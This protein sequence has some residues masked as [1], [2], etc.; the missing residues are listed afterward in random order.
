V[1]DAFSV[2]N[3]L[4]D[5]RIATHEGTVVT[6]RL[7]VVDLRRGSTVAVIDLG[8]EVRPHSAHFGPDGLLYVS[9][10][11]ANA[12]YI[13]DTKT[14]SLVGEIPTGASHTHMFVISPDGRRICTANNEAGSVSVLDLPARTLITTIPISNKCG[15]SRFR[16]MAGSFLRRA[17][18]HLALW[19]SIL[20]SNA[21]VRSISLPR[22]PFSPQTELRQYL[23]GK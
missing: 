20:Q 8:K 10:E 11:L 9:A 3:V 23:R 2:P 19:S 15:A 22:I 18:K 6:P 1:R 16:P 21:V 7:H 13:V 14:R 5:L 17:R 4:R 12:I